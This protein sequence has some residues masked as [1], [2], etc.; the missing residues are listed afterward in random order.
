[1]SPTLLTALLIGGVVGLAATRLVETLARRRSLLDIPN[2]R[3][4]HLVPTPR[5]GGI[6]I[7]AGT[8]AGWLAGGGWTDPAG[9]WI[10]IIAVALAG[11]GL[12][13]DLGRSSIAGKYLAQ[14]GAAIAV[15]WLVGPSLRIAVGGLVLTL[16]GAPA[17]VL[18]AVGITA[19]INAWNFMDGIDGLMGGVTVIAGAAALGLIEPT[20]GL[21]VV[22]VI[23]ATTGF[24]VW[25]HAPASVFMGD[26]G[27]QFLGLVIAAT[28]LGGASGPPNV[29][30][31]G[32]LLAPILFDTGLTLAR[33]A[34]S[35]EDL[36]A[37]HR[38]H[39]YQRL[40]R[41]GVPVRT[42]AAGYAAVVAGSGVAALSWAAIPAPLQWVVLTASLAGGLGYAAWVTRRERVRGL[43]AAKHEAVGGTGPAPTGDG[44]S[45]DGPVV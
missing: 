27:S 10:L 22:A 36:F 45:A 11:I 21:T 6:G 7:V 29:V 16:D 32:L 18:A 26:A 39:L 35:R 25:N 13:D 24:L 20:S 5:L 2:Q 3:S 43:V 44:I 33:R 12:L 14:L 40:V 23:G 9:P 4:S 31:I 19:V 8:V 42:V 41:T 38:D 28:L 17:A 30:P 1:M 15:V 34:L 37:A